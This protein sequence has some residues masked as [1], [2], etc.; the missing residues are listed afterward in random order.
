MRPDLCGLLI[1][2]RRASGNES[3]GHS[4]TAVASHA[5]AEDE[6]ERKRGVG[7]GRARPSFEH[8][9][10]EIE[11][12]AFEAVIV[13]ARHRNPA[14]GDDGEVGLVAIVGEEGA[15]DLLLDD[16]IDRGDVG[17][18]RRC[19]GPDEKD[20]LSLTGGLGVELD[21]KFRGDLKPTARQLQWFEFHNGS[22]CL[23]T[24]PE[25]GPAGCFNCEYGRGLSAL[26]S[27]CDGTRTRRLV[28][29]GTHGAR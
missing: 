14:I 3:V 24:G 21:G 26:R 7:I 9:G 22:F 2:P 19:E 18:G 20:V 4:D 27:R 8:M 10:H 1:A 13:P 5:V 23:G 15:G 29:R 11:I 28:R 16:R 25:A 12:G 17:V 6:G